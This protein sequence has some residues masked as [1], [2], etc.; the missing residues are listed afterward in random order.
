MKLLYY[1]AHHHLSRMPMCS[2]DCECRW[3]LL[4]KMMEHDSFK[5]KLDE[6]LSQFK[7][8]PEFQAIQ[9]RKNKLRQTAMYYP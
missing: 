4:C 2:C 8:T 6:L 9:E 1:L 7:T 5:E 3:C